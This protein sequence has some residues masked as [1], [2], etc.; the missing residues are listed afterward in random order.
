MVNNHLPQSDR[1]SFVAPDTLKCGI[2]S[3][4]NYLRSELEKITNVIFVPIKNPAPWNPVYWLALAVKSYFSSNTIHIQF[5]YE[6]FGHNSGVMVC[7]N[8]SIYFYTL[9]FLRF[10]KYKPIAITFHEAF[11]T[12]RKMVRITDIIYRKADLII[13]HTK[14]AKNNFTRRGYKNI[15]IIAHGVLT[16]E[17][18]DSYKAK[19]I[20]KLDNRI[21]IS[22][23]GYIQAFKNYELVFD[24]LNYLP[25]NYFLL[26]IGGYRVEEDKKYYDKILCLS[27]KNKNSL[28]TGYID[29]K[30]LSLYFAVSDF[31]LFPYECTTQSGALAQALSYQKIC[32]TSD[33]PA[34]QEIYKQYSNIKIVHQNTLKAWVDAIVALQE[35]LEIRKILTANTEKYIEDNKWSKIAL[36]HKEAFS[37]LRELNNAHSY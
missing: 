23:F 36:M 5:N 35:S 32:L 37:K 3:Y 20:L 31:V 4:S 16:P 34:F 24:I 19:K 8:S 1:I 22:V 11:T 28:V 33:L 7:I 26:C 9:Y 27:K 21:V 2:S 14:E 17:I 18:I 15:T 25:H 6:L 30:K 13:V 12:E 10:C 29:E